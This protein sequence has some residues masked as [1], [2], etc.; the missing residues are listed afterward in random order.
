M[1]GAAVERLQAH[2]G[3]EIKHLDFFV[4]MS[5]DGEMLMED[6]LGPGEFPLGSVTRATRRRRARLEIFRKPVESLADSPEALPWTVFD[7]VVELVADYVSLPPEQIHPDY[8][9]FHRRDE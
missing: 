3:D 2:L 7:V 1:V 9:G 8:R 4:S 5:P 6:K